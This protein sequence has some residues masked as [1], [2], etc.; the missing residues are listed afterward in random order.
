MTTETTDYQLP[1]PAPDLTDLDFDSLNARITALTAQAFPAMSKR[2]GLQT[3]LQWMLCHVGEVIVA[4][5]DNEGW[6][7][8]Y[9]TLRLRRSLLA[10]AQL[11]G[12]TLTGQAAA[13]CTLRFTLPGGAHGKDIQIGTDVQVRSQGLTDPLIFTP[14]AAG[15]MGAGDT[16]LDLTGEHS[17]ERAHSFTSTGRAWQAVTLPHTFYLDG[18]EVVVALDGAYSRVANLAQSAGSDLH[19]V[20]MVDENQRARLLFGNGVVGKIPEGTVDCVYRTGGGENGNLATAGVLSVLQTPLADVDGGPV[21]AAVVN[22]T[23]AAGGADR[24]TVAQGKA[25]LPARARAM[26]GCVN[27]ESYEINALRVPAVGRAFMAVSDIDSEVDENSGKLHLIPQGQAAVEATAGLCALVDAF[28]RDNYP[29][30]ATFVLQVLP[31]PFHVVDFSL[32][33]WRHQGYTKAQVRKNVKAVLAAYF[34]PNLADKTANP[35]VD[36]GYYHL[37]ANGVPDSAIAWGD[38]FVAIKGAAG[39]RKIDEDTMIPD[40]DVTLA[41]RE[42][43]AMGDLL[44]TDGDSGEAF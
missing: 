24:T 41:L 35:L 1:A 12:E 19:Y 42:F 11:L 26:K 33:I 37:D 30:A 40:E 15:T 17:L 44:L 3:W 10:K 7:G 29:F 34:A 31:A 16:D 8:R 28:L 27:R 25:E 2:P 20:V 14:T 43:P 22:T 9:R 38:L 5:V 18:S 39:V 36:F 13:Q 32:R 6:E 4:K 23:D 21:A